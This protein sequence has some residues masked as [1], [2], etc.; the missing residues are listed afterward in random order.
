MKKFIRAM[1]ATAVMVM[2]GFVGQA[3][4]TELVVVSWGGAY[5]ASQQKAYHAPYMKLNP[6]ITIINDD[7]AGSAVAKLRAMSQAGNVTWDLVDAVASDT[8]ILCDEGIIEVID[9][10]RDLAPAPDG[11][12]ASKDFGGFIISE[13]FVPQIV[14]S[15]TFGYR[16]DLVSRPMSSICDIFDL[17]SFPV[18]ALWRRSQSITWNGR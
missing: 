5:T 17:K 7:S 13:C 12:P 11:T 8:M 14:Y 10:D 9:H 3:M 2:V 16:K 4:A 15:T 18:N 6:G 1:A